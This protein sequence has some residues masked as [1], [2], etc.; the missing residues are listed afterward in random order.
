MQVVPN[1]IATRQWCKDTF[2]SGSLVLCNNLSRLNECIHAS[3]L[4]KTNTDGYITLPSSDDNGALPSSYLPDEKK[5]YTQNA[6]SKLYQIIP[7]NPL[8]SIVKI[9]SASGS[10]IIQYKIT[11]NI[12]YYN[13]VRL[14]LKY[15][16]IGGFRASDGV[17]FNVEI[18]RWSTSTSS[19]PLATT[20]LS[21]I[22]LPYPST[23]NSSSTVDQDVFS[24][25]YTSTPITS[26]PTGSVEYNSFFKA[27]I[28]DMYKYFNGET[29]DAIYT[30]TASINT[31]AY[32]S[33]NTFFKPTYFELNP[34]SIVTSTS[35]A[36]TT[37]NAKADIRYNCD[38]ISN[39]SSGNTIYGF[40]IKVSNKQPN[41]TSQ[42][43]VSVS[44][45]K[46]TLSITSNSGTTTQTITGTITYKQT[47]MS[48]IPRVTIKFSPIGYVPFS[49]TSAVNMQG[50][51]DV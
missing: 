28:A 51:L 33:P 8:L 15:P 44:V 22:T 37:N 46:G 16:S 24:S 4:N 19:N 32:I 2:G 26:T 17:G 31:P 23:T 1:K 12:T 30:V 36:E 9:S 49:F 5:C 18:S 14:A 29:S 6:I 42:S 48:D 11:V 13:L 25:T 43:L 35:T 21:G 34:I 39:D 45:N 40:T 27:F 50:G 20:I 41:Q 47:D 3:D 10:V 7:I 38:S